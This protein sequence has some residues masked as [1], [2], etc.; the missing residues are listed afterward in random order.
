MRV[1]RTGG[2]APAVLTAMEFATDHD[3][4]FALLLTARHLPTLVRG[5]EE[6][7]GALGLEIVERR[8]G[9][10]AAGDTL[11]VLVARR[12]VETFEVHLR[13]A[14]E[15]WLL[16]DRDVRPAE[17]DRKLLDPEYAQRKVEGIVRARLEVLAT[18][19]LPADN[20]DREVRMVNLSRYFERVQILRIDPDE[21]ER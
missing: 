12:G 2:G 20:P 19:L 7:V 11:P 17:I 18:L 16:K 10:D 13:N 4:V 3:R 6:G 8:V 1:L 5:F 9:R 21:E 15:D 14:F